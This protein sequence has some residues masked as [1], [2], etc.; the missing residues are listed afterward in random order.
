[1]ATLHAVSDAAVAS[2]GQRMSPASPGVS[3]IS[4][5]SGI[6]RPMAERRGRERNRHLRHRRNHRSHRSSRSLRSRRTRRTRRPREPATG[7]RVGICRRVL[8]RPRRRSPRRDVISGRGF[9]ADVCVEWERAALAAE[10]LG[11]RVVCVR[12]GIVLAPGGGAL[13]KM[14]TPF[15]MGAGG[16]L[17]DGRQWM[18]RIHL[19]KTAGRAGRE[20][21]PAVQPGNAGRKG[22][23]AGDALRLREVVQRV[24]F[25]SRQG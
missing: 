5:V 8:R 13:S 10:R 4:G 18:P 21:G 1:M 23:E 22:K 2:S 12:T 25:P 9:L 24:Q 20:P 14:L 15:R 7:A 16:R 6:G 17:G 11:I 3:W 19:S